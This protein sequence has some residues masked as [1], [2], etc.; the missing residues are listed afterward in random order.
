M[1]RKKTL[2]TGLSTTMAAVLQIVDAQLRISTGRL[3]DQ[4]GQVTGTSR[5]ALRACIHRA[6]AARQRS[7]HITKE[8]KNGRTETA[9]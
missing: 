9:D 3:C 8:L 2:P 5:S 1:P 6:H 4:A 7:N